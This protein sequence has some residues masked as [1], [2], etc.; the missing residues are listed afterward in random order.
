MKLA[1]GTEVLLDPEDEEFF[2]RWRWKLN[3]K[4][5]VCRNVMGGV[6]YL[7][8]AV[9]GLGRG[10]PLEGDHVH[11][12]PLDNRRDSLRAVTHAQNQQNRRSGYGTSRHRGVYFEQQTQKWRAQVI[13]NGERH[14]A[15]RHETEEAAAQAA[16]E[17]RG[18]LM[19]YAATE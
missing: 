3:N 16:A 18:R 4:G 17:L 10:N 8:R 6:I 1:D 11:G 2:G 12:D 19:P 7:H 13:L 14:F 15:G 5:Y 9:L